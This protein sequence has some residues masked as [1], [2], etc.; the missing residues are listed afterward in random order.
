MSR[1]RALKPVTLAPGL[2]RVST[3]PAPTGSPV[4]AVQHVHGYVVREVVIPIDP[5]PIPPLV[6]QHIGI[7]R[8]VCPGRFIVV[9]ATMLTP[10]TLNEPDCSCVGPAKIPGGVHPHSAFNIDM[11]NPPFGLHAP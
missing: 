4:R 5:S 3:K 2:L 8:K 7:M 6:L 1:A 9:Y 11:A 10:N